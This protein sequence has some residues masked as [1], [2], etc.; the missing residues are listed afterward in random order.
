M[1]RNK[2]YIF[3]FCFSLFFIGFIMASLFLSFILSLFILIIKGKFIFETMPIGYFLG[4]GLLSFFIA[5]CYSL[6]LIK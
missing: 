6:K 5:I 3:I 4:F 2:L 1:I